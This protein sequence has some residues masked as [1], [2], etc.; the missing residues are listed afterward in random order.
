MSKE[1]LNLKPE[2]V[3]A[4]FY[5]LTQIPRP[6]R[7]MDAVVEFMVQFA[8]K[9]NLEVKVDA[10]KNVLIVKPASEAM[11]N[12]PTVILQSHLDMVPQKNAGVAHDFTKD[13]IQTYIE[14]GK[15]KAESTT[16]GAD[17][18]IGVAAIMAVLEDDSLV[19]GKIEALFT[20]DEE[21]GMDG[22]FGLQPGFLSGE[23]LLNLDTE[24]EGELCV[25]CAGGVDMTATFQ[26]KDADAIDGDKAFKL[27]LTGLKGGHSGCDI[28]L[29]RANANKLLFRLLKEAV[30]DFEVRIAEFAGG[31][32]RNAIPREAFAVV[33]VPAGGEN[34]F[35]ELVEEY[36]ILYKQEYDGIEPYLTLSVEETDAP[37]SILPE[38]IQDSLI[39]AV[40][41]CP[42]GLI[43]M[44]IDFKGTVETS[45]NIAFVKAKDGLAEVR[46]LIRSSSESKKEALVS[47]IESV[48]LLAGAK[49]EISNGYPGWKPNAKSKTLDVMKRVYE[50]KFGKSPVVQVVHA[51]L[52]C[53]IILDS[54]PNLDIVS[55]GPTIVNPHSP[56]EYVDIESVGVFYEY[57]VEI[58][59]H[60]K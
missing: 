36:N 13:P 60:L 40:V 30:R 37:S 19:H 11:K 3:W 50:A 46:F 44:L 43:S 16:L 2:R 34:D 17:N 18:G 26:Y 58:L 41:G 38:E 45:S 51:G 55:F 8:K 52:E 21:D 42:N 7:H 24:E 25:G 29:G 10:A 4:H 20:T 15:V 53:G 32:L 56:D 5:E 9:L 47:S 49:V 39:N 23:I 33:T 14:D 28:H 31:S 35:I 12:A 6:T 1:I 48:F 54:T 27:G 57:L 59:Q 22:A